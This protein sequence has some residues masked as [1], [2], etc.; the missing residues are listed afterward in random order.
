ME[1]EVRG[2]LPSPPSCLVVQSRRGWGDSV[3]MAPIA[4]RLLQPG[5]NQDCLLPHSVAV[6]T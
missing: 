4:I 3:L 5:S 2:A 6:P 1:K